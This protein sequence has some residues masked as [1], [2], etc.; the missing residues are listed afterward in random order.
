M[1]SLNRPRKKLLFS[2]TYIYESLL[3]KILL[4]P[5]ILLTIESKKIMY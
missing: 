3:Q 4:A 5:R 1:I 2:N